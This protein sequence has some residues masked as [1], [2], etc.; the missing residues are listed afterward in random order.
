MIGQLRVSEVAD[1]DQYSLRMAADFSV[2]ESV[3]NLYPGEG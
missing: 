2:L 3:S 1:V